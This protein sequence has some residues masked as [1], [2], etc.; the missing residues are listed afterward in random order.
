MTTTV[1]LT[2]PDG[3]IMAT[4]VE[5][6]GSLQVGATVTVEKVI[7]EGTEITGL[8]HGSQIELIRD[9]GTPDMGE[10]YGRIPWFEAKVVE[11]E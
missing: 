6:V 1:V 4:V 8:L 9:R 5:V 2:A 10:G 3:G 7:E 11:P